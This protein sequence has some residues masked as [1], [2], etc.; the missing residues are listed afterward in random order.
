ML[1]HLFAH[2]FVHLLDELFSGFG[3]GLGCFG[4]LLAHFGE[5]AFQLFTGT[6]PGEA[7]LRSAPEG[8]ALRSATMET[9]L[10]AEALILA[11]PFAHFF[12]HLLD[13]FLP[14][15]RAGLGCFGT[16][17]AHFGESAFHLFTGS[18]SGEAAMRS[19]PEEAASWPTTLEAALRTMSLWR[20]GFGCVFVSIAGVFRFLVIVTP[21]GAA[22]RVLRKRPCSRK[23]DRQHCNQ[24]HNPVPF[25][26]LSP[27]QQITR[28]RIVN[29]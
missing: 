5:S 20:L 2:S 21:S 12:V 17:L 29:L 7:A 1:A 19:A 25:H 14:G 22:A 23:G 4:T 9:A 10:R 6:S 15:L 16:F 18:P 8:P 26:D 28:S 24:Q 13:E 3:A 11:H 27:L